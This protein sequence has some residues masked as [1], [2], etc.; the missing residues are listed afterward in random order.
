MKRITVACVVAT[1]I[2]TLAGPSSS[3]QPQLTQSTQTTEPSTPR[4]EVTTATVEVVICFNELHNEAMLQIDADIADLDS[5]ITVIEEKEQGLQEL[6]T[7][8]DNVVQELDEEVAQERLRTGGWWEFTMPQEDF[9]LYENEYYKLVEFHLRWDARV[10]EGFWE[11]TK[12]IR[13]ENKE[14]GLAGVLEVFLGELG[15]NHGE[16][17]NR[18][19][20]KLQ[21]QSESARILAEIVDHEDDWEIVKMSNG[22]Y[23]VSGYGLGYTDQPSFGEWY[24]YEESNSIEPKDQPAIGLR[25]ALAGN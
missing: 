13:V 3:C 2:V 24:Y 25:D 19:E 15:M 8:L 11:L 22:V 1:L 6:K 23:E 12:N 21:L 9:G 7:Q 14:T 10:E 17:I 18:K 4:V 5:Q 20:I 16:L